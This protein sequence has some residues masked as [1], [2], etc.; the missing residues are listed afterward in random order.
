MGKFDDQLNGPDISKI[1]DFSIVEN[2]VIWSLMDSER[3]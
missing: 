1:G 3:A 2:S